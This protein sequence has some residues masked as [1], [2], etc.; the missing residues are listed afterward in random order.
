MA[1]DGESNFRISDAV[2]N[3]LHLLWYPF[4]LKGQPS[5]SLKP[6]YLLCTAELTNAFFRISSHN[7]CV[8]L[9]AIKVEFYID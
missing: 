1:R 9:F 6:E 8:V 5:T 4:D 2:I 3:S 7:L